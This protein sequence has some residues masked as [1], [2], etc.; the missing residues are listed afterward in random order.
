M[1]IKLIGDLDS[2]LISVGLKE[3]D[4]VN[5]ETSPGSKSGQMYFTKYRSDVHQE[6]VVWP[7]NYEIVE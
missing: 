5:A 4:I 6:C 2:E 1:K 7:E 3:G